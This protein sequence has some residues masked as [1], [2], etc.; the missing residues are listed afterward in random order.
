MGVPGNCQLTK[1]MT[2]MYQ[3]KNRLLLFLPVGKYPYLTNFKKFDYQPKNI[4]CMPS[5]GLG[6]VIMDAQAIHALKRKFPNAR[7]SV[8]VHYNLGGDKVCRLMNS[9]DET[10]DIKLKGYHWR[11]IIPFMLG[12]FWNLLFKL[13]KKRFDLTVVFWPNPIRRL[14]LAGIGSK[15]WLYSNLTDEYPVQQNIRLLKQLGIEDTETAISSIFQVPE[16]ADISNLLPESLPRPF[17][18]VHPFCGMRWR[19][20]DKFEELQNE[21]V[22]L[23]GSVIVVGKRDG[24]KALKD[25]HNLVNNL[26]IAELF[27]VIKNCDVFVTADSGPMHIGFALGKSTVAL[28]GPI[29]PDLRVPAGHGEKIKVIY[30]GPTSFGQITYAICRKKLDNSAMRPITVEEVIKAVKEFLV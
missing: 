16:P 3:L 11:Q 5:S 2:K 30:K 28:F 9:V 26:S 1:I 12:R 10:I 7:L 27:W 22:K 17:I 21:L 6:D 23:K 24:Y 25:V 20:W 14:L 19:E 8:L 15:H 13:R 18:C 29:A 4:L